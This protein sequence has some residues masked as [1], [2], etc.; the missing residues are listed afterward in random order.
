MDPWNLP[1][2]IGNLKCRNFPGI[3]GR[4]RPGLI[5]DYRF[6]P[7]LLLSRGKAILFL[8]ME[9]GRFG[10]RVYGVYSGSW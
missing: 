4:W 3:S 7:F 6:P 2:K 5:L 8:M 1:L 9:I 10:N